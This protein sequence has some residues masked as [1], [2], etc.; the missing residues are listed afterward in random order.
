MKLAPTR[1]IF[2]TQAN[3]FSISILG[4]TGKSLHIDLHELNALHLH[5]SLSHEIQPLPNVNL[6][7]YDLQD[8]KS[9]DCCTVSVIKLNSQSKVAA[10]TKLNNQKKRDISPF[11]APKS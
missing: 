7:D 3:V 5:I 8:V 10:S 6:E 11:L 1:L 9:V 2:A 4:N